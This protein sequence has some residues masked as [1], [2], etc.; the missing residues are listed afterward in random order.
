MTIGHQVTG[1][2]PTHLFILHGW[3][4]D[5]TV[6]DTIMPWFDPDKYTI[7]R[8]DYRGYG[9]SRDM[10][11]DYSIEEIANDALA[12]A[13]QLGWDKFHMLGHSMGGMVI[14]KMALKAPDRLQSA[15]AAT[16][17]PASGFD[18]DSDTRGFFQSSADDDTALTEIF[19]ILT[20]QRH[21]T[22]FLQ[23]LTAAA[24]QSTTR[25]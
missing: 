14:Q 17:V 9:L 25:A 23:G 7:A 11:G 13:D 10:E 12:L 1:N 20:G 3:L 4:S 8:M 16:P 21:A 2:G 19:N 5:H 6:Y 22:S 18:M 15:I 24:R